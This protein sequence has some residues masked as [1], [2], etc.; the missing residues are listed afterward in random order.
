MMYYVGLDSVYRMGA[1][2]SLY[3]IFTG[4]YQGVIRRVHATVDKR[5]GGLYNPQKVRV[6]FHV[7]PLEN[8][9][10]AK[11]Y[12]EISSITRKD[13]K[14]SWRLKLDGIPVTR[15][16]TPNF[17]VYDKNDIELATTV[18]DVTPI[19][20]R[21]PSRNRHVLEIT[22]T[23]SNVIHVIG[24]TL[25]KLLS[26]K[27]GTTSITYV[28]GSIK[29]EPNSSITLKELTVHSGSKTALSFI[30]Y[31][32]EPNMVLEVGEEGGITSPLMLA[33]SIQ[34][35][36]IPI[37]P[38]ASTEMLALTLKNAGSSY[39]FIPALLFS[40]TVYKR[41]KISL[42]VTASA[43]PSGSVK[44]HLTI[45]NT[46]EVKAESVTAI[47]F[48]LGQAVFREV[49]GDLEAGESRDVQLSLNEV[50][51]LKQVLV[52]VVWK[53]LGE[54]QAVDKRVSLP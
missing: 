40:S 49:L 10:V 6:P 54:P 7:T 45:G 50:R 12:V 11:A 44:L 22:N 41:P 3:E 5:V 31:T 25:L 47:V 26:Y 14:N 46:G 28:G 51:G 4:T 29:L 36:E 18:I 35:V 23:G 43:E 20:K 17:I 8:A 16:Y 27:E 21:D 34:D 38:K 33:N 52:R 24:A 15:L 9:E 2:S 48:S 39:V 37:E 32:P 53:E 42:D 30:A 19:V 1:S 13:S